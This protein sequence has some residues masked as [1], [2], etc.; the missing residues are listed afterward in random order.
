M[1]I[2]SIPEVYGAF[3][4]VAQAL[5]FQVILRHVSD[6]PMVLMNLCT[7]AYSLAAQFSIQ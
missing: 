5:L 6:I 2:Y 3:L 1:Q 4:E 7:Y